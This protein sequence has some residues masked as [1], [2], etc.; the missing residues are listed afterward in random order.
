MKIFISWSGETSK[1]IA[2]ALR[3]W[4]PTI[5]QAVDPFFS[6]DDIEKGKYWQGQ[7]TSKL[8]DTNFGILCMTS[9]NITSTWIHYEAG[10][11]A[12][13]IDKSNVIP[14]TFGGLKPT[15]L[16]FPLG[17][18]QG[19]EFTQK[20]MRGLLTDINNKIEDSPLKEATINT[21]FESF[22]LKFDKKV[23]EII[24]KADKAKGP[25]KPV[26]D[27]REMIEEMLTILRRLDGNPNR[28]RII[29]IM[30]GNI[31][32]PQEVDEREAA[33]ILEKIVEYFRPKILKNGISITGYD[34]A[35]YN[36]SVT[37]YTDKEL[38]PKL[39]RQIINYIE[40]INYSV[41]FKESPTHN[42]DDE[43]EETIS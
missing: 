38:P 15:D 25:R 18:L 24:K 35:G 31:F 43:T 37:L 14:I 20:Y 9:D 33:F 39:R 41:T 32:G 10:A 26:R 17:M 29:D 34:V 22:W 1:Q 36:R 8:D 27:Q 2:A 7:I 40:L 42:L 12:K 21:L 4:L 30:E 6:S 28:R 23:K 13:S 3:D 19:H 11:L 5:I 16:E